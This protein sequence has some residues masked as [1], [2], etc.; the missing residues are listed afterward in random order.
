[1]EMAARSAMMMGCKTLTPFDC[2]MAPTAKGKIAPPDP[3]RAVANPIA[4]T[5]RCCGSSF[6]HMMTDAGN[7]GPKTNPR[8]ATAIT[9]TTKDGTS[10]KIN[11][12]PTAR[13]RYTITQIRSPK[14]SV[15][16]PRTARPTVM[17]AQKPV[18]LIPAVYGVAERTRSMNVTVQPPI[19]TN[20]VSETSWHNRDRDRIA[21]PQHQHNPT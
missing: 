11:S 21:Y 16:K 9:E 18:A 12:I 4:V 20:S 10:Q 14:R 15:T 6:V 7:R 13:A 2:A 1:M 3:P 5:W 19:A 17:P 8:N